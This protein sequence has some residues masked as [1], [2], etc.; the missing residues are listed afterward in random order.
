MSILL[1]STGRCGV[2]RVE[3]R[4]LAD[5]ERAIVR[6]GCRVGQIRYAGARLQRGR[7]VAQAPWAGRVLPEGS[8]VDLVVSLGS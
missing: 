3:R 7:V 8:R 4:P 5:A 6:H 1:N 2:P